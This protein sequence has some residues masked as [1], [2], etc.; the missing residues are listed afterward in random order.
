MRDI[1][2][3]ACGRRKAGEKATARDIYISPRFKAARKI[4][5]K[6]GDQWFILSAK[7]HLL[8]PNRAIKPYDLSLAS[9]SQP[10]REDWAR[11]VL[12]DL[13]PKLRATDRVTILAD[14]TYSESLAPMIRR[15]GFEIRQ[16]LL[17]RS[18]E[19]QLE[20][21]NATANNSSRQQHL[22]QFYGLLDRLQR[23]VGGM[24]TF[25]ESVGKTGWP[26]KGVYFFFEDAETRFLPP[27]PLRVVRVGTHGV[28]LGSRS[29][30]WMRL[31]THRGT[32][33]GGGGHRSSIL[34]LHIGAAMLAKSRGKLKVPTWGVG[35]YAKTDI[36]AK[37]ARLE[38]AVSK[39]ISR[40][41]IL[42]LAINDSS[43][44]LSDRAYIERNA[45]SL[46]AGPLGPLDPASDLWLGNKSPHP[47]IRRSALWN[48]DYVGNSYDE[49]FLEV[50]A[51]YVSVTLGETPDPPSS[52]APPDWH[53]SKKHLG[54]PKQAYL[55]QIEAP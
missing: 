9:F 22:N 33:S 21:L 2:L 48:V 36:T 41:K 38:Q 49:R 42:W 50:L 39:Y 24:R 47:A 31:R 6:Y 46:L 51:S 8:S 45:I 12:N 17:D 7:Y 3:V 16:P 55:F 10:E 5:E 14:E 20:W 28:S 40:M 26:N 30:L 18:P 23:G 11:E 1:F 4:A 13:L 44:P 35:Q 27:C 29:T 43:S 25:Q 53:K 15:L 37:E 52:L 54:L 34:R 32:K 19:L